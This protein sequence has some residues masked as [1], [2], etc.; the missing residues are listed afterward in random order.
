LIEDEYDNRQ[1]NYGDPK[2]TTERCFISFTHTLLLS[3][4]FENNLSS[5]KQ[6]VEIFDTSSLSPYNDP[7]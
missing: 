2:E 5:K 6:E 4:Y 3:E 7:Q 1:K